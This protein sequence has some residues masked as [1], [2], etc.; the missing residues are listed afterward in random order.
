MCLE[1]DLCTC[2][3]MKCTRSLKGPTTESSGYLIIPFPKEDTIVANACSS[4]FSEPF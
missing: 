2:M 4:G 3:Y 1:R